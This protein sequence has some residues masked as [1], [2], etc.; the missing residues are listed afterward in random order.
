MFNVALNNN[1]NFHIS[2]C[3]LFS[4]SMMKSQAYQLVLL[5]HLV[6]KYL[7]GNCIPFA[8]FL[9]F[10]LR[11]SCFF[12]EKFYLVSIKTFVF[13]VCVKDWRS[14]LKFASFF[15]F[16]VHYPDSF[17]YVTHNKSNWWIWKVLLLLKFFIKLLNDSLQYFAT[18]IQFWVRELYEIYS[19]I[20]R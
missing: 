12:C 19:M 15:G 2:F 11:T 8:F 18:S 1:L 14:D 3:V 5:I 16:G 13:T 7:H 17:T 6:L 4:S 20:Y 9:L 10:H